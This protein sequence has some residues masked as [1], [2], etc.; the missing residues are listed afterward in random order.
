MPREPVEPASSRFAT[1]VVATRWY[2]RLAWALTTATA[3]VALTLL[4]VLLLRESLAS[5]FDSRFERDAV[6]RIGELRRGLEQEAELARTIAAFSDLSESFSEPIFRRL[7]ERG[8]ERDST[9]LAIAYV[10]R[11]TGLERENFEQRPLPDGSGRY[12]V[13]DLADGGA[14]VAAPRRPEHF[15]V[16]YCSARNGPDA[17]RS[18]WGLDFASFPER[19]AVLERAKLTGSVQSLVTELAL[20]AFRDARLGERMLFLCAPIYAG[21]L[22]PASA[23][24]RDRRL[25]GF[26][27]SVVPVEPLLLEAIGGVDRRDLHLHVVQVEEAAAVVPSQGAG[28]P[29]VWCSDGDA[30]CFAGG[31]YALP[32]L[33]PYAEEWQ[34]AGKRWRA[35]AAAEPGSRARE[36]NRGT[37]GAIAAG[38]LLTALSTLLVVRSLQ[39][40]RRL[41]REVRQ[42]WELSAELLCVADRR[43]VLRHVNPAWEAFIGQ[44]AE[45]LTARPLAELLHPDDREAAARRIAG[46][47]S[48][49]PPAAFEARL[50][51][52]NGRWRWFQWSLSPDEAGD[53]VHGIARDVTEQRQTL[54]ELERR[55][56]MDPLTDVL[57]RRAL[58]E[59]LVHEIRRSKRYRT[60]LSL[61][62]IDLDRFK[63]VNDRHGHVTGDELL[64]RVGQLLRKTLRDS[65][66][67]GRFGGDEFVVV[68]PQTDLAAARK[69][70]ARILRAF[71][72]KGS[73]HAPDGTSVPLRASIG[74][75]ER[76][77]DVDDVTALVALADEQ[78]YAAKGDG[79]NR[80]S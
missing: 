56:T 45:V 34:A 10:E 63:E 3:G 71:I 35:Y 38:A 7:V 73:V 2:V 25:E 13:H 58:F 52:A 66:L 48:G 80:I 19:L 64:R 39:E 65:D 17:E 74:V 67:A 40:R 70:A 8:Q 72:A 22:P 11:V 44:P 18:A 41:S 14:P 31:K 12:R 6:A 36:T 51:A 42:F 78:L 27:V 1:P 28:S 20:E 33:E 9:R 23:E 47:R 61:A 16:A 50:R 15:P 54:A 75:A 4:V 46:L 62:V 5:R 32:A 49:H 55:A 76:P 79:R 29:L 57:T 60:P 59:R 68:M 43:G 26:V 24:E 30:S 21:Q 77:P 37:A 53:T 69:A